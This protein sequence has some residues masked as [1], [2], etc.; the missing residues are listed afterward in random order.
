MA[1]LVD[2]VDVVYHLAAAVGVKLIVGVPV[3]TIETNIRLHRDRARR[4]PTRRSGP[5]SSPRRA[6]STAR[7]SEFPFREDGDLRHGRHHQ[8]PLVL[9]L[10][11]RPSTSSSPSPTGRRRS[12]RRSSRASSTPSARARPA[13]TAW[14]SPTSC[15]RRSRASRSPSSAT[16]SSRAAS[17][18]S[19]TSCARSSASWSTPSAYGQVFNIG[20]NDEIT[21]RRPG[22]AGPRDV[23]TRSRRSCYIPYEKAYEQGFEDMP[24]RVPGPRAR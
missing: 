22:Q 6:R 18:T 23:P 1:E 13:S 5:S 2:Q 14:S 24:R 8:G 20:N 15:A 19:P 4:S 7:A 11:P 16:A 17:P 12:S 21:H 9:R 3:R 10:Q